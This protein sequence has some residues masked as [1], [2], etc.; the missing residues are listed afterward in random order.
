MASGTMHRISDFASVTEITANTDLD[1][2]Q[3][4]GAF[5]CGAGSIAATLINCPLNNSGFVME[6]LKKG[7]QWTQVIH[8]GSMMYTRSRFS[9]G[10]GSWYKYTGTQVS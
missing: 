1:T 6:V 9:D 4:A 8:Q 7:S 5:Y 2:L 10:W 3:R